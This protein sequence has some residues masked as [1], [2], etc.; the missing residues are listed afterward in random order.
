MESC[1][2]R[3]AKFNGLRC[4]T[5]GQVFH[6]IRKLKNISKV[7]IQKLQVCDKIYEDEDIADGFFDSISS[8]KKVNSD[9]LACSESYNSILRDYRQIL[10]IVSNNPK[11]PPIS[12]DATEEI[13][14]SLKSSVNDF[15]MNA[16]IYDL[17]NLS[18]EELNNVWACI[19]YEGH[20]K[21]RTLK[22]SYRNI[23]TC[24]MV[25]KALDTYISS[26]YSEHWNNATAD[27]QFQ[28]PSS[29]HDLAA[30]TLT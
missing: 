17:N 30:L 15:L 12:R 22:K 6:D 1:I 4:D 19:L 18:V 5:P 27:T 9:D 7:N 11:I 2:N 10:K 24:P 23:T 16:A 21:K 13:L 14:K 28:R 25:C 8:L 29:S 26:L 3:H 20:Y